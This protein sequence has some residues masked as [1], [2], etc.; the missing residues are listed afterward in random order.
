[1]GVL[2]WAGLIAAGW[3]AVSLVFGGFWALAAHRLRKPRPTLLAVPPA[4]E[5]IATAQA[6]G[7]PWINCLAVGPDDQWCT[8]RLYRKDG[9][10]HTGDHV[11]VGRAEG[12]PDSE[13]ARWA[14]D[15]DLFVGD[16]YEIGGEL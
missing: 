4:D 2:K 14:N 12:E 11:A 8:E 6:M 15:D 7:K 13:V 9:Y 3:F 16:E 1:M 5:R 10:K